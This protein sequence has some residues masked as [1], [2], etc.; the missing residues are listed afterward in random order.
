M[1]KMV[2]AIAKGGYILAACL[3]LFIIFSG[4]VYAQSER[5]DVFAPVPEPSRARLIERLKLLTDHERAEHW[6]E[7]Y[8]MLISPWSGGKD[9]YMLERKRMTRE[10]RTPRQWFV[11]FTPQRVHD[12]YIYGR[13]EKAQWRID[14]FATV[15]EGGCEVH[16][17]AAVYI[18]F[19]DNDWYFSD[20]LI[21][22]PKDNAPI[23][24]CVDK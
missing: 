6:A 21:E 23:K 10:L 13:G 1:K 3:L 4:R 16:R 2:F 18:T 24:P 17:W 8:D 22:L 19:R 15:R 5:K 14:G 7:I 9:R 12:K 11:D 20:F